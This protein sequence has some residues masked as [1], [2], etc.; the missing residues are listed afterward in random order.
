MAPG[1]LDYHTINPRCCLTHSATRKEVNRL[2]SPKIT[3]ELIPILYQLART[4]G[5]PMTKL[6]DRIIREALLQEER[7][8]AA[9]GTMT[10]SPAP[11]EQPQPTA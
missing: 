6:V 5:V 7:P 8:P 3:E 2:Y 11:A 9:P 10:A 4:R 1:C